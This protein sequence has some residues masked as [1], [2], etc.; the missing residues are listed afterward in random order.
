MS[1]FAKLDENN[2]VIFVTVGKDG[3][4]ENELSR[5]TGETYKR[6]SYNTRCGVHYD[7]NTGLPSEDQSKSFRKNYAGIG[8]IYDPVKD[9]F[10]SPRP[11]P[12][13]MFDDATCCWVCPPGYNCEE[14]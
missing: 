9:A 1:H 12:N 3:D 5:R 7:P 11:N 2:V 10:I 8:Y 14:I 13:Y 6:T 4:D